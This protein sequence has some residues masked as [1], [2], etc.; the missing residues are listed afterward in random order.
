MIPSNDF[1][2][3]NGENNRERERERERERGWLGVL[4]PI[5]M[6]TF[7]PIFAGGL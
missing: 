4:F 7:S 1:L 3:E 6:V 5:H 2:E